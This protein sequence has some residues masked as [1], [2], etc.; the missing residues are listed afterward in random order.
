MERLAKLGFSQSYTYFTWRDT[1]EELTRYLG[2]LTA[3]PI[4]EYFRPNFWPNTPDI[5][6]GHLQTGG[7]PA[8]RSRL[9]LAATLAANYGIYGPAFELGENTPTKPGSEEYLNSEKYEIKSWDL[10]NSASLKP[11]ITKLNQIR[12]QNPALQT[13][14]R[15]HFH[16]TD[17]PSLI[18]YSKRADGNIVLAVVNLDPFLVQTGWVELDL[19]VLSLGP[20]DTFE[21][22]DLLADHSYRWRGSRNYVALRPAEMPAHLFRVLAADAT[23][24]QI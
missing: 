5:L 17:N 13:N 8:F 11:L 20:E 15:I 19:D 16:P 2:E 12:R 23:R 7:L 22:Y 24:P 1:K 14:E 9:V 10:Q 18:C 21:V 3:S 6:P 4:R